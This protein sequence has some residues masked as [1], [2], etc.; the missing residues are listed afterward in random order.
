MDTFLRDETF[1]ANLN[2]SNTALQGTLTAEEPGGRSN[3]TFPHQ[4][5]D[6]N[7]K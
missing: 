2:S 7:E 4:T 3:A 1:S 6:L 5:I